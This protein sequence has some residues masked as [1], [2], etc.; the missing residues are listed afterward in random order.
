MLGF[1]SYSQVNPMRTKRDSTDV[2]FLET[3]ENVWKL[4]MVFEGGLKT[5][6]N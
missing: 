3:W 1:S 4:E 2:N 6:K 5:K